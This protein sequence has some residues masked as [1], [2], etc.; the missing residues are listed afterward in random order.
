MYLI[1]GVFLKKVILIIEFFFLFSGWIF[2]NFVYFFDEFW[3][4]VD[5]VDLYKI[6]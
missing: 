1:M 2:M 4:I 3:K 6:S 5:S